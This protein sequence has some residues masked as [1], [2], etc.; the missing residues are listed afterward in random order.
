[1]DWVDVVSRL[2]FPITA[3]GICAW[4]L[5]YV[6]DKSSTMLKEFMEKYF[7]LFKEITDQMSNL[8]EAVNTNTK[9]LSSLVERKVVSDDGK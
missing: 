9:V 3:F 8:T 4:F 2:G 6:Y 5:K 7:T 1:M